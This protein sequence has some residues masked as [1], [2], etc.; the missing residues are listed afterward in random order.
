MILETNN[1]SEK[2]IVDI[3]D[4]KTKLYHLLYI[5][6]RFKNIIILG[7]EPLISF[8]DYEYLEQLDSYKSM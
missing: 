6:Y 5:F 4:V 3:L 7:N 2:E 1:I 8:F